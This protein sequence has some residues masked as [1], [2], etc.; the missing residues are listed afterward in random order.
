M[1]PTNSIKLLTI[2]ILVALVLPG[3]ATSGGGRTKPS[4]EVTEYFTSYQALDDHRYYYYGSQ[5]KPKALIG[6]QKKYTLKSKIWIEFDAN[7]DGLKKRVGYMDPDANILLK[8]YYLVD[9]EGNPVGVWYSH[10][11]SGARASFKM[12]E[13]NQIVVYAPRE[14]EQLIRHP[15][16]DF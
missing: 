2:T 16:N 1:N 14:P 9:S 6:I 4:L 5:Y 3:C 11:W 7:G 15:F 8:G 13:D 10:Q 12:S